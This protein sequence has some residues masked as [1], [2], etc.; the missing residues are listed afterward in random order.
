MYTLSILPS[1]FT[2]KLDTEIIKHRRIKELR[3]V[4]GIIKPGL[5][6]HS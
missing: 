4:K 1:L 6:T 3:T 2:N 5:A